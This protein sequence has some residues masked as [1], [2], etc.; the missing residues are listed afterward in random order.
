MAFHV[1]DLAYEPELSFYIDFESG[2]GR[3]QRVF[4][5]AVELISAF[6]LI[7]ETL[8]E[9]FGNVKS[10]MH[11]EEIAG[12]SIKGTLRTILS[13]IDDSDIRDLNIKRIIGGFL[14][15]AK[16]RIL[17][18]ANADE[19]QRTPRRLSALS[20]ELQA[21]AQATNV[22][23]LPDYSKPSM[24]K[25]AHSISKISNAKSALIDQDRVFLID[26][27][28]RLEVTAHISWPPDELMEVLTEELVIA[29]PGHAVLVIKKP[30]FLGK[31]KWHMRYQGHTIRVKLG[32]QKWLLEYQLGRTEALKPG[33]ALE[34]DLEIETRQDRRGNIVDQKY[35]ITKVHKIHHQEFQLRLP[36]S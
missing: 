17:E 36:G 25:L 9:S 11:L 32:D 10:E 34:V 6:Q 23:L 13:N 24:E 22:K 3:P 14:L 31:S 12:G 27:D 33:D 20:S 28:R 2:V 8:C 1:D 35:M 19:N 21:A 29:E 30:D 26:D 15:Q 7:D 4:E 5:S 18:W 16:Y